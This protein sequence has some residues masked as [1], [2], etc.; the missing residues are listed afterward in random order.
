MIV[1]AVVGL[2]L[3]YIG[4]RVATQRRRRETEER[5]RHILHDAEKEAESKK[6]EASLE[7]QASW[8]QAKAGIEQEAAA[9]KLEL[10]RLEKKNLLREENLERKFEHLEEKEHALQRRDQSLVEREELYARKEQELTTLLATQMHTLEQLAHMT[11]T[12]AKQQL[13]DRMISGDR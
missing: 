5:M 2:L 1:A 4:Q 7:A 3:G 10:Q 13:M 12:E 6:R 11:A 9:T 8:Y